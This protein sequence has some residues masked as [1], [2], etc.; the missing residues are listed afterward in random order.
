MNLNRNK[1]TRLDVV[2]RVWSDI[3]SESVGALELNLIQQ[4]LEEVFGGGAVE[5]PASLARILADAGIPMRHPEVLEADLRWREAR[6]HE[7]FGPGELDFRTINAAL[8]SVARIKELWTQ[9]VEEGDDEALKSLARHIS[10][11][12][13]RLAENDSDVSRE[14]VAWLSV[15][16]QTPHLF[17]NWLFLRRESPDFLKKFGR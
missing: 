5:S 17:A 8:E 3:N 6:I 10:V 13:V 9:F 12:K 4:A 7:F 15:W 14:V 16:L 11:V 2:L 1:L